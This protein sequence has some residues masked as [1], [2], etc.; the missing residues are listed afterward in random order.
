MQLSTRLIM[1]VI[2]K[3]TNGDD[4]IFQI[5][6]FSTLA[7][8]FAYLKTLLYTKSVLQEKT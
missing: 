5:V 3:G 1:W 8:I 2:F 6:L 4:F 7:D